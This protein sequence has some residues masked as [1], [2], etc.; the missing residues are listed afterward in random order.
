MHIPDGFLSPTVAIAAN[1]GAA[2]AIGG[3]AL[4]VRREARASGGDSASPRRRP[5]LGAAAAPAVG[6]LVFA[7]QMLNVHVAGGT[8]GHLVGAVLA[9]MLLGPALGF[10]TTATVLAVQA[11]AFADGGA[12]ALGANVLVMGGIGALAASAALRVHGRL[13]PLAA[14]GAGALALMAGAV[15]VGALLE[16]SGTAPDA[17]GV[18]A[19][20]HVPIALIEGAVTGLVVLVASAPLP[21]RARLAGSAV[22]LA[23]LVALTPY[24]SAHPD[25][26]ERVAIDL[27]FAAQATAG[28]AAVAIAPDYIAP[29]VSGVTAETVGAALLG[30]L[31]VALVLAGIAALARGDRRPAAASP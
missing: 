21:G 24:A 8:S 12:L 13:R 22:L 11:L 25:G 14:A 18:M 26:L 27:G 7:A 19:E 5:P 16:L 28:A 15:I 29:G 4:A 30:I 10:L 6:A 1:A 9:C 2:I 23:A 3:A 31:L 17:I 20:T